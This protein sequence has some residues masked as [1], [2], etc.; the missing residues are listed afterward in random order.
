MA[1]LVLKPTVDAL[2]L[3]EELALPWSATNLGEGTFRLRPRE[4][5]FW[6]AEMTGYDRPTGTLSLRITDYEADAHEYEAERRAKAPVH[7]ITFAPLDR[8]KFCAQ[9]LFYRLGELP[10]KLTKEEERYDPPYPTEVLKPQSAPTPEPVARELVFSFPF[11]DLTLGDGYAEGRYAT[12]FFPPLPF[13]I[14]NRHLLKEFHPIRG[15]FARQLRRQTVDVTCTL[16]FDAAGDPFL[17]R[18][19]SPQVASIDDRL[20]EVLRART[21]HRFLRTELPDRDLFTPEELLCSYPE[22]D[23]V[24]CLL[25]T[26][27]QALLEEIL[28]EQSVRNAPQL[29]HLVMLH[30]CGQPLRFVL[31]PRFGFLFF[32]RGEGMHHFCLELLDS[33]ATYAWSLPRESGTLATHL[34]TV[35]LEIQQLNALGRSGYRRSQTFDGAFWTVRHEHVTSEFVD[36]FPRWKNRL[37]EGLV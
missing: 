10:I 22:D 23:P 20:V 9:L 29:S 26:D 28:R 36:G 3:S 31:T 17:H 14:G 34:N 33:H 16:G 2:F 8:E 25:P 18:A 35:T 21:L 4:Q 15:Y 32:V 27:G 24:R 37:E 6:S 30:E 11:T 7:F 19:Q 13:R 12:A 1:D 5:F